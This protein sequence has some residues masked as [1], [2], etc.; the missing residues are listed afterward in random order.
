MSHAI[1][2][3][4]TQVSMPVHIKMVWC[5]GSELFITRATIIACEFTRK[6]SYFLLE[7]KHAKHGNNLFLVSLHVKYCMGTSIN[8][9]FLWLW[10]YYFMKLAFI[11]DSEIFKE[12]RITQRKNQMAIACSELSF[13]FFSSIL[14]IWLPLV[15]NWVKASSGKITHIT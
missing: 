12:S 7:Q 1:N 14:K 3:Y 5:L 15:S 4:P 13:T 8:S 6:S 11:D 9:T 10:N 2:Y